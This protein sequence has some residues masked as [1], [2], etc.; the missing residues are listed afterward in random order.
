MISQSFT[1]KKVIH[2]PSLTL[3]ERCELVER[4]IFRFSIPRLDLDPVFRLQFEVL[5]KVINN[6]GLVDVSSNAREVLKM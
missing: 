2:H 3:K 5:S 1:Y 4:S 6:N